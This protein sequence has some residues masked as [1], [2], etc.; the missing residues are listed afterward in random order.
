[1]TDVVAGTGGGDV[2]RTLSERAGALG[3]ALWRVDVAGKIVE[4][5]G[6]PEGA[7][8]LSRSPVIWEMVERAAA[9]VAGDCSKVVECRPGC[10]CFGIRAG[11][12]RRRK[13]L[14]IGWS[15]T[16][17][18]LGSAEFARACGEA[19][20]CAGEV[21]KALE[22]LA[23]MKA[24]EVERAR[25]ALQWSLDDVA[26]RGTDAVTIKQLGD[27][28]AQA[29][30]ETNVLF[31][32]TRLMNGGENAA[33]VLESVCGQIQDVMP[34][35]WM[36]MRFRDGELGV[37]ELCG[38]LILTGRP[39]IAGGEL[40]RFVRPMLVDG[41]KWTKLL[42]PRA[43]GLAEAVGSYVYAEQITHDDK[44]IGALLAGNRAG[45][46]PDP[47]SGEMQLISATASL[48]GIFHENLSRFSEQQALFMGTLQALTA[49][50]D[51][52]DP[53]TCGHSQRVS[54]LAAAMVRAMGYSAAQVER[55]RIAGLVHDVGKIGVPEA[56]LRKP[57]RLTDEE[58]ALIKK[59]PETGYRILKDIPA[60]ADVLP[61]VLH[62][63]EKWDGKGYPHGLKGEV[64]PMLGRV[65]ALADTF[66]AMSSTRAY[67][68]AMSRGA[69]LAEIRRCA[70]TQFDPGLVEVFCGLDFSEYDGAMARGAAMAAA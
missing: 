37:K 5:V 16:R 41:A 7:Q 17:E 54:I 63:H 59:H 65:L 68:P 24:A 46:D 35:G 61:G 6:G 67:R 70:G 58:F 36:A 30:E 8:A 64:I 12:G 44:V 9:R 60:L 28:L 53:Y 40:D 18:W 55:Y 31:R 11:Q 2:N 48:V 52:K 49:S 62:H 38:R 69:V 25:L 27:N 47:T 33:G 56:V 22:P 32:L 23:V 14:L 26:G 45:E 1:M 21:R 4:D 57:G 43:G 42:E 19:A 39:P 51:A 10:W 13:E 66:D 50:I 20:V 3:L 15:W 34:Y 29:Y